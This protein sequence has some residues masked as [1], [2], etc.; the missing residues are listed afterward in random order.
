MMIP[1]GER[2]QA[3]GKRKSSVARVI[4]TPGSGNIYVRKWRTLP[5]GEDVSVVLERLGDRDV[6]EVPLA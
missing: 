2:W 6:D 4:L 5:K 3:T 1:K